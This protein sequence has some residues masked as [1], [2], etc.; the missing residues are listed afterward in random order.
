M[1]ALHCVLCGSWRTLR[2]RCKKAVAQRTQWTAGF[3]KIKLYSRPFLYPIH[4]GVHK[5]SPGKSQ[6]KKR[7]FEFR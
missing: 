1:G 7:I 2:C 4:F 6:K 3:A 5:I